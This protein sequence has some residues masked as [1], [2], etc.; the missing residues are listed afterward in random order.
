MLGSTSKPPVRPRDGSVPTTRLTSS[1]RRLPGSLTP[2]RAEPRVSGA[3]TR[4][5]SPRR[6]GGFPAPPARSRRIAGSHGPP[7]RPATKTRRR[8]WGTRKYW[9]SRTR[10]TAPPH[11]PVATPAPGHPPVGTG[12]SAPTKAARTCAK[13]RPS[14]ED[15]L[16][17]TFSQS[18]HSG[19][20][21]FRIRMK[22]QKRRL[23]SPSRPA[24]PPATLRFW[25]GVPPARRVGRGSSAG[26]RAVRSWWTGTPG[27]WRFRTF[28]RHGSISQN[29]IVR[30]P[31]RRRPRS[32]PPAPLHTLPTV[33]A[34][35]GVAEVGA[36]VMAA[37]LL[38]GRGGYAFPPP[39]TRRSSAA[40]RC[41]MLRTYLVVSSPACW[42]AAS[43]RSIRSPRVIRARRDSS[44]SFSRT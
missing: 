42:A 16:P 24:R 25:Q 3:V 2:G 12:T 40:R 31:A 27:Q 35:A 20:S 32:R 28:R 30:R 17:A 9:A 33:A 36:V 22:S 37:T 18:A 23:C 29:Q 39:R 14:L 21:A 7:R 6:A 43:S 4:G 34:V 15:R 41:S 11:G 5:L 38:R 26:S 10:Q 1:S 19:S 8:R 13:S 44:A